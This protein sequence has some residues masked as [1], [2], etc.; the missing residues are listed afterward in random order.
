MGKNPVS[1][2]PVIQVSEAPPFEGVA[3]M[4]VLGSLAGKGYLNGSGQGS[5][6]IQGCLFVYGE[7]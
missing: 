7:L 5:R 1:I 6:S 3:S 4:P 2:S